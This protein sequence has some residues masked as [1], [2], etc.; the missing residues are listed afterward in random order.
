MRKLFYFIAI[1]IALIT[2]IIYFFQ[3]KRVDINLPYWIVFQQE[4]D[5]WIY[6]LSLDSV[7]SMNWELYSYAQ[8]FENY[9]WMI[10]KNDL[11]NQEYIIRD[12]TFI[13]PD[14]KQI[15]LQFWYSKNKSYLWISS[16]FFV[17]IWN[18]QVTPDWA[19]PKTFWNK[20]AILDIW[21]KQTTWIIPIL[22]WL[23]KW[24]SEEINPIKLIGYFSK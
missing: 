24:K 13:F 14:K 12:S 2:I 20:I 23:D 9:S 10:L 8:R 1:C 3:N 6:Y 15:F 22:P 5:N 17:F 4:K 11:L 7:F 21:T 19:P 16:L 18:D